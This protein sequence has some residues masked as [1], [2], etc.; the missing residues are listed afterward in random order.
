MPDNMTKRYLVNLLI[1][2]NLIGYVN[3]YFIILLTI[4]KLPD[5]I[6]KLIQ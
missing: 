1:T 6:M 2:M 5:I 3:I 4:V